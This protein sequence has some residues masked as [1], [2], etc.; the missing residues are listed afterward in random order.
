M[1]KSSS[2]PNGQ[3]YFAFGVEDSYLIDP[4]SLPTLPPP[5]WDMLVG[6][7]FLVYVPHIGKPDFVTLEDPLHRWS[8]PLGPALDLVGRG[9]DAE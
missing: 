7:E 6:R 1:S 5:R 8:E 4:L 9:P 2:F 3:I